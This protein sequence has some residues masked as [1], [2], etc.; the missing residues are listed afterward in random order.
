MIIKYIMFKMHRTWNKSINGTYFIQKTGNESAIDKFVIINEYNRDIDFYYEEYT[1]EQI[2]QLIS[3]IKIFNDLINSCPRDRREM[4]ILKGSI[5]IPGDY[6]VYDDNELEIWWNE[7]LGDVDWP[8]WSNIAE[9]IIDLL[10]N[11]M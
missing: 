2:D 1:Q 11:S 4:V 7:N 10:D 5:T 6:R 8:N 9:E 3:T